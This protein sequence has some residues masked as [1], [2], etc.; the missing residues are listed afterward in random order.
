MLI[1][2]GLLYSIFYSDYFIRFLFKEKIW[3]HRTNSIEKLK[4]VQNDYY[5]VELDVEFLDSLNVFD[6]NHPPVKSIGLKLEDYFKDARNNLHYW[7]DFK[8]LNTE[9]TTKALLHLEL[10]CKTQ[11]INFSN[12]IVE[13]G[14]IQLLKIYHDKGFKVS[15]YL[16]WPGLYTL[17]SINLEKELYNIDENL[18][19][20]DFS[21]YLSSDYHDYEL[22]K[23]HY[24]KRNMLLWLDD[25]FDSNFINRSHLYQMLS[26]ENVKVILFKC[27]SKEKER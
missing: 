5:G 9:N 4:E 2:A 20:L 14:N 3:V 6:V 15:Y 22:L 23:K 11:K 25:Q 7:L 12:V 17:D 24:P 16:H 21:Y 19:K 26:D 13:S 8:N 1:G 27:K 10:I 18:K